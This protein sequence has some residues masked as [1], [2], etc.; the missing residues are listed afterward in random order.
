MSNTP[1]EASD[2]ENEIA[3]ALIYE[4]DLT[5][6]GAPNGFEI[7]TV[8][9]L[10]GDQIPVSGWCSRGGKR[11]YFAASLVIAVEEYDTIPKKE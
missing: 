10:D 8:G 9:P 2:I 3:K 5:T 7:D 11:Y 1:M 6:K 4:A